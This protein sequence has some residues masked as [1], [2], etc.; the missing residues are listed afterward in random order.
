MNRHESNAGYNLYY[1]KI[2][3]SYRLNL[4]YRLNF[5]IVACVHYL[6]ANLYLSYGCDAVK[7]TAD[8]EEEMER[9]E[10]QWTFDDRWQREY[11]EEYANYAAISVRV[12][13]LDLFLFIYIFLVY[14]KLF[15]D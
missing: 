10:P 3:F 4:L 5:Q 13:L 9:T 14:W 12:Q 2:N 7:R 11:G 1:N 8:Q 6:L 15:A